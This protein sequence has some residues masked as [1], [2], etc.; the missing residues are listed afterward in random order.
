VALRI[1]GTENL[2]IYGA[3]LY[4][5]FQNYAKECEDTQNCQD[6]M[7]EVDT[8]GA[9]WLYNLHTIGSI[10][11]I[12]ATLPVNAADNVRCTGFLILY[13][14]IIPPSLFMHPLFSAPNTSQTK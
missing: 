1:I 13:G 5:W 14:P 7:V 10:D 3:G 12:A 8:S 4:N 11:M 6:D 2:F 9:I